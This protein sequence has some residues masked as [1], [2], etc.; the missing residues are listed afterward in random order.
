MPH[1]GHCTLLHRQ[2]DNGVHRDPVAAEQLSGTTHKHRIET[3]RGRQHAHR[4]LKI[5]HTLPSGVLTF[6]AK[7][8]VRPAVV[9]A[10]PGNGQPA[11]IIRVRQPDLAQPPQQRRDVRRLANLFSNSFHGEK[12]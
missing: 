8:I 4:E 5:G 10:A 6:F 7:V 3:L 2:A 1:H 9:P 12:L 11:Q